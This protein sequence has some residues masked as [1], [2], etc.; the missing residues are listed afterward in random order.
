MSRGLDLDLWV[1]ICFGAWVSSVMWHGRG[2]GVG[3][4][5]GVGACLHQQEGK[6]YFNP[7]FNLNSQTKSKNQ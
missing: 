1:C 2:N 7:I 6:I 5:I 4:G 3:A